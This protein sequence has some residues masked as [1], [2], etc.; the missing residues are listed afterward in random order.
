MGGHVAC[1]TVMTIACNIFVGKS[2][3]RGPL[4]RPGCR[5]EDDIKMKF[6]DVM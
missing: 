1:M 4:G 5:W 6:T 2:Q 3:G